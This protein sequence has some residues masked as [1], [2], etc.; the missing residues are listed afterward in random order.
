[1]S[2][3][4]GV[5]TRLALRL[6]HFRVIPVSVTDR[7]VWPSCVKL[8]GSSGGGPCPLAVQACAWPGSPSPVVLKP[9]AALAL[10]WLPNC[11][12][13]NSLI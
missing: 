10:L 2:P 7:Q 3:P 6:N 8:K 4:G 9:V 11:R 13:C 12:S 5:I 1:M